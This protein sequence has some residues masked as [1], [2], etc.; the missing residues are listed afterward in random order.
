MIENISSTSV[1]RVAV[2]PI[3]IFRRKR[4]FTSFIVPVKIKKE[5]NQLISQDDTNEYKT[6]KM[7]TKELITSYR[8]YTTIPPLL[9]SDGKFGQ[10]RLERPRIDQL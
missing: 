8:F 6:K 5:G 3:V 7:D 9:F 4:C 1:N 2:C 10:V